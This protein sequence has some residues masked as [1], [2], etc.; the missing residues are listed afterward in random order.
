MSD[1]EISI[2]TGTYNRLKLLNN[3][4][5]SVRKSIGTGVPY[6][7]IIVDGGSKDGTIQWCKD[8]SDVHR[9]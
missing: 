9:L 1:I 5:K 3:M 2:V 4:V 6:E 8:Q 7:I